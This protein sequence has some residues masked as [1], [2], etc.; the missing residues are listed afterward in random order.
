MSPPYAPGSSSASASASSPP[1]APGSS[2]Y[3]PP[4]APGSSAY[5]PPYAPGSSAYAPNANSPPY[6]PNATG[7]PGFNPYSTPPGA[8]SPGVQGVQGAQHPL[9]YVP[10]ESM[11]AQ[12]YPFSSA[13]NSSLGL[14]SAPWNM[15]GG[16][17]PGPLFLDPALNSAFALLSDI[18]QEQ[19][20]AMSLEKREA[21]MRE[22]VRKSGEATLVKVHKP[23]SIQAQMDAQF[24]TFAV[25][26]AP[27]SGSSS[28]AS[29]SAASSSADPNS[30]APSGLTRTISLD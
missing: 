20:R 30:S 13:T 3:S 21:V 17:G 15:D 16:G 1:Y 8:F 18:T 6:A 9:T 29:S 4:Y 28:A 10:P 27:S 12:S 22:I 11:S 5:S 23:A 14:D 7:S 19:L 26:S 2:A 24:P 25:P